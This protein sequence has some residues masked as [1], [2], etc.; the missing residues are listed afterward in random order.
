MTL[1]ALMTAVAVALFS[2]LQPM[3]ARAEEKDAVIEMARRRFL[4]GVRYFDQKHYEEARAA[5]LQAYALKH[6]PAV[7]LNLAQSEIRSGHT[8]EAARHFSG[9]LKESTTATPGEKAEAEKSLASARSKL[10]KIQVTVNV[11]GAEVLVDGESVG[12]APLAEPVDATPGSHSVVARYAGHIAQ[13]EVSVA[14]GRATPATLSLE[15]GG[16]AA[17]APLPVPTPAP[18]PGA[19]AEPPN[20]PPPAAAPETTKDST[21][22]PATTSEVSARASTGGREPFFRW[23]THSGAG[24]AGLSVTALGVG[25]GA[26]F[27]IAGAVASSNVDSVTTAI[28]NQAGSQNLGPTTNP[29]DPVVNGFQRACTTLQ[30][31]KDKRDADNTVA[32]VGFVVGGVGAVATV[33]AYFVSSPKAETREGRTTVVPLVG[34]SG[35]GLAVAG[36]F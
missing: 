21:P 5:F 6:H 35:T 20:E 30:D 2:L 19:P 22:A 33:V 34:S 27:S 25:I 1:R 11:G 23:L 24:L 26:G 18:A 32:L 17:S 9:F 3:A 29:C 14:V 4:E 31:N 15:M 16:M 36:S 10:G 8:L 7:L 13:T 12:L 28:Q